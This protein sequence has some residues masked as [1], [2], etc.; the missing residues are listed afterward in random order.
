MLEESNIRR[1]NDDYRSHIIHYQGGSVNS[2]SQLGFLWTPWSHDGSG[3]SRKGC[4]VQGTVRFVKAKSSWANSFFDIMRK[5]FQFVQ[6]QSGSWLYVHSGTAAVINWQRLTIDCS[7]MY[8]LKG[9]GLT[10]RFEWRM[11]GDHPSL[12][13]RWHVSRHCVCVCV[14]HAWIIAVAASILRWSAAFLNLAWFCSRCLPPSIYP[15]VPHP[16]VQ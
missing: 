1:F 8:W 15:G 10:E 14:C 6:K 4:C 9:H 2:V 7:S 13:L 11:V 5:L 12:T 3:Q 16:S